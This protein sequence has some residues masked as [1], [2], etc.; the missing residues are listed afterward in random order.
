MRIYLKLNNIEYKEY[1]YCHNYMRFDINFTVYVEIFNLENFSII[2]NYLY[3]LKINNNK[4]FDYYNLLW[5]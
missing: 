2:Q 4:F 1:L 3:K 5:K